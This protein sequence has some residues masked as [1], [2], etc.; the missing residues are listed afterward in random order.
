MLYLTRFQ[1]LALTG[2]VA[3]LAT[4]VV[5]FALRGILL[6]PRIHVLQPSDG[7]VVPLQ[8]VRIVG[9]AL[10]V[11]SLTMNGT[12]VPIDVQ[13]F[14]AATYDPAPGLNSIVLEAHDR[15]GRKARVELTLVAS[16]RGAYTF[17]YGKEDKIETAEGSSNKAHQAERAED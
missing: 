12:P 8:P 16:S 11:T 3:G 6:G 4:A 13:G 7:A 17:S 10:Q 1:R 2:F 14:F 9:R 5:L 15:I